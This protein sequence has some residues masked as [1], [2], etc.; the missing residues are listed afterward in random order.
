MSCYGGPPLTGG[1]KR[2]GTISE[3]TTNNNSPHEDESPSDFASSFG[4]PYRH[5]RS[6]SNGS[7][8][9]SA[10]YSSPSESVDEWKYSMPDSWSC[11]EN[12]AAGIIQGKKDY[13]AVP[14]SNV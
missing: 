6:S 13:L 8:G 1:L 10:D 3:S 2:G 12:N 11:Q 5:H 14:A 9:L 4:G 7:W